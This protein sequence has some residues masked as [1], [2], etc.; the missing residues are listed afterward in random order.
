MTAHPSSFDIVVRYDQQS[1]KQLQQYAAR[2]EDE[3]TAAGL[4]VVVR[5]SGQIFFHSTLAEIPKESSVHFPLTQA[6]AKLNDA[7]KPGSWVDDPG[8]E[9]SQVCCN[10]PVVDGKR[11]GGK[12]SCPSW[13]L[14]TTT[15][16]LYK[17]QTSSLKTD[18]HRLLDRLS[19]LET[20]LALLKRQLHATGPTTDPLRFEPAAFGARCDG[21][22][23]DTDAFQ[24]LFDA[25]PDH[26]TITLPNAEC[27]LG[28]P[29]RFQSKALNIQGSGSASSL[30]GDGALFIGTNVSHSTLSNFR[31]GRKTPPWSF[32][33]LD[34]NGDLLSAEEVYASLKQSAAGQYSYGV[35]FKNVPGGSLTGANALDA[36]L[37]AEQK[38]KFA[39]GFTIEKSD[40]LTVERIRG[41]WAFISLIHTSF[42][43]VRDNVLKG[44]GTYGAI[45]ILNGVSRQYCCHI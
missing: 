25:A 36:K 29:V 33:V 43:T 41:D 23:N 3:I 15:H 17:P 37:T 26:G 4:P 9:V 45:S 18:E 2:V 34:T 16:C 14:N 38:Q 20:E 13:H 31:I 12:A 11:T 19:A 7:I 30:L 28:A 40:H 8:F 44:G 27:F 35:E 5:R 39:V 1:E 32:D 22:T 10:W 6:V 21:Q 24:A 42:S